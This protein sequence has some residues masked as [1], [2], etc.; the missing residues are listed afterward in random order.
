MYFSWSLWKNID[1]SKVH[2][3]IDWN[4][5]AN[6]DS[7]LPQHAIEIKTKIPFR[8]SEIN[9][10][11]GSIWN[12][13]LLVHHYEL[14]HRTLVYL[15]NLN[16]RWTVS[17]IKSVPF[18]HKWTISAPVITVNNPLATLMRTSINLITKKIYNPG[19]VKH[20]PWCIILH[21]CPNGTL[22]CYCRFTYD[23]N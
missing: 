19:I 1:Y 23:L 5:E 2:L 10:S 4:S 8:S 11:E 6:D 15:N 3:E 20:N 18:G 14:K 7:V 13:S 21:L 22:L 16:H 9:G 17:N 12:F